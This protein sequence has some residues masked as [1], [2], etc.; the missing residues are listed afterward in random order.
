MRG[1]SELDSLSFSATGN[2]TPG[3]RDVLENILLSQVPRVRRYVTGSCS[4]GDEAVGRHLFLNRRSAVHVVV[5]PA[6]RSITAPWWLD[7]PAGAVRLIAMPPGSSRQD[8]NARLVREGTCLLGFP[9]GA[10]ED[11]RPEDCAVWQAMRISRRLHRPRQWWCLE[12]PS[13]SCAEPLVRLERGPVPEALPRGC[14][15]YGAAHDAPVWKP[16][17]TGPA[18]RFCYNCID[19][20]HEASEFDHVCA[21]CR[22]PGEQTA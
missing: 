11:D 15:A 1:M 8:W 9:A 17:S 20:C 12:V 4:G 7:Y 21:V 6:D 14:T 5:V 2:L 13:V 16:G 3:G 22:D 10:E 18:G 19:R